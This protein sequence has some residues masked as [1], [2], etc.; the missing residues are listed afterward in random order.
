MIVGIGR[1]G[2]G[3]VVL[4]GIEIGGDECCTAGR[5]AMV[6]D[7][8]ANAEGHGDVSGIFAVDLGE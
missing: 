2:A 8:V 1:R 6:S 4:G 7:R 3:T 5:I